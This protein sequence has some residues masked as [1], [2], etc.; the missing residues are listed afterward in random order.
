MLHPPVTVARTAGCAAVTL[1]AVLLGAGLPGCASLGLGGDKADAGARAALANP[2]RLHDDAAGDAASRAA[3]RRQIESY[4]AAMLR[5]EQAYGAIP[6]ANDG[7]AAVT[8]YVAEGIG[9]VDSYCLRWFQH[10]EDFER[11][12]GARK[13]DYNVVSALGTALIGIAKLHPDVTAVYGAANTAY[14]GWSDNQQQALVIAPS[15]RG[16]KNKVMTVMQERAAQIRARPGSIAFPQARQDL[17]SYADLCTYTSAKDLVDVSIAAARPAVS[18]AGQ[19]TVVSN[20]AFA[21]DRNSALLRKLWKPDGHTIDS[22]VQEKLRNWLDAQGVQASITS[23]MYGEAF[24]PLR[25]RSL[26]EIDFGQP[27]PP[28]SDA[29]SRP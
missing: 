18:P 13:K 21:P 26:Q 16:V 9:L 12:A 17:E 20:T 7:D 24:A 29:G 14:T 1:L 25:Q 4:Y 3:A 8:R 15:S 28:P 2:P 27:V 22:V 6:P 19:F 23:V 11:H 10:L 5:A